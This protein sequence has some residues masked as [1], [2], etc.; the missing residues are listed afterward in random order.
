MGICEACTSSN[1]G[2]NNS[3]ECKSLQRNITSLIMQSNESICEIC[4]INSNSV[5]KII[6]FCAKIPFGE[7]LPVLITS[8]KVLNNSYFISENCLMLYFK[9][10]NKY[11][12][13]KFDVA[14]KMYTSELYQLCIIE[15]KRED[16]IN[17][18][19]YLEIDSFSYQNEIKILYNGNNSENYCTGNII[20]S[21]I[22]N[23][24][25][26]FT[27]SDND[28]NEFIPIG[29]PILNSLNNKV[30]GINN[31]YEG[32]TSKVGIFIYQAIKEFCQKNNLGNNY[33][34]KIYFYDVDNNNKYLVYVKEYNIM[35]GELIVYFYLNSGLEFNNNFSFYYNNQEIPSYST[36]TLINLNI[37]ENSQIYFKRNPQINN[38]ETTIGVCFEFV[39]DNEKILVIANPYM[40]VKELF[41]KF[42]QRYKHLY[43]HVLQKYTLLYNSIP[44]KPSNNSLANI[45][46]KN[47]SNIQV[48]RIN[49]IIG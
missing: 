1:N 5:E 30:I 15:I 43:H 6:G 26:Y 34:I 12:S 21:N 17:F 27:L 25:F 10:R 16:N 23:N 28:N 20:N 33:N 48:M 46:L 18:I 32:S 40:S 22:N 39:D 42:C 14:R 4:E 38:F 37:Q 8:N 35:F 11:I 41:L 36:N 24:I 2:I 19:S 47:C 29:S 13:L 31:S 9:K 49:Q 7:N 3:Q 45:G 44:L